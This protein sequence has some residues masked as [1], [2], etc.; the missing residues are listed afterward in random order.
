[1]EF[2][3]PEALRDVLAALSNIGF[4]GIK[5]EDLSKLHGADPYEEELIVMA[6]TSAYFH[7]AYKVRPSSSP[8]FININH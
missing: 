7:I 5:E 4:Q 1:M 6:E 2:N 8:S 3:D